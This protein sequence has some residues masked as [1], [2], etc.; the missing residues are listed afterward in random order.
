MFPGL[1]NFIII[2]IRR[3]PQY[4]IICWDIV[5]APTLYWYSKHVLSTNIK[6]GKKKPKNFLLLQVFFQLLKMI[7][8]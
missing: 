1:E 2:Q 5:V 7:K 8:A 6:C 3:K 4:S